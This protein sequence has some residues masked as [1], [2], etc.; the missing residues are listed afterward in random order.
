MPSSTIFTAVARLFALAS[1]P[2]IVIPDSDQVILSADFFPELLEQPDNKTS[3]N[4]DK[5]SRD[6]F[7]IF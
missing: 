1:W 5:Q 2:D 6:F 3:I 7:I 4:V